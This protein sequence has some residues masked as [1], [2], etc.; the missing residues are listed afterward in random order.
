M[1]AWISTFGPPE[2]FLADNGGEFANRKFL[3]VC[4]DMNIRVLHTAGE[5]PWSNGLVERHNAT[6]SEMLHKL[7]EENDS[8][9]V[10]VALA[11]AVQAKNNLCNVHGFSPSQLAIGYNPKL[12]NVLIDK[13]PA[14]CART[15]EDI[16]TENLKGMQAARKAFIEAESSEK[17]KRALSHNIRPGSHNKF[18][19]GDLV[20]YKRNDSRKW[21]GPGKV[22]G[23]E[24]SNILIKHGANYV[25]VHSY[26]VMLDK[27]ASQ[28]KPNDSNDTRTDDKR[29]TDDTTKDV[30]I[31]T[32]S[33]DDDNDKS[34]DNNVNSFS[35]NDVGPHPEVT[36]QVLNE[37]PHTEN[38]ETEEDP[39]FDCKNLKLKKG[40]KYKFIDKEGN[41][42]AGEI[43]R[44][45]GKATGKF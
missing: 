11:W 30:A 13:P 32:D 3:D 1:K 21:K 22:I 7:V 5:S 28:D 16:I 40:L 9:G 42:F 14:L 12:P 33:S 25:R 23:H 2:K 24:S 20:Y 10:E 19:V 17:I 15:S 8:L 18:Y 36:Q 6:L 39:V 27:S 4:E 31:D 43:I 38:K 37:T 35:Q 34:N 26:R 44:R 41:D 29:V 45:T